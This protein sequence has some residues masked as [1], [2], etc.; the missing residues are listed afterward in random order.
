MNIGVIRTNTSDFG[1][2]G[3]YNVQE[4]GLA[5]ALI[6]MGHTVTVLYL[7][8]DT[9]KII[10]DETYSFVFYLPHR[11]IGLHGI[12]DV[13]LL[14]KY[15]PNGVILFSDNQLWAK[16]VIEWCCKKQIKCIQYM[17]NVLSD[18]PKW[19]HQFYTKLILMRNI[20]SYNKSIN[21]SKTNKVKE[22]MIRLH[23]P[24]TKIINIGLDDSILQNTYSIDWEMRRKLGFEEDETVLLFIGRI[25][26]YKKPF[27]ACDIL[28]RLN[29]NGRKTKMIMIGKGVLQNQL[30]SYIESQGLK[31]MI[32]Y[33]ERVPYEKIYQYMVSS[34]CFINLSA[35]EIFG[36]TV[37][38]AMY[39]KLPVVVHSAPGPNDIVEDG[40]TGY[41]CESD[42]VEQWCMLI[43]KALLNRDILGES[44]HTS[45]AENFMWDSSAGQFM[46]LF[47]K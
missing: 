11:T 34:N 5:N 8:K 28:K 22:E 10:Q 40:K 21:V 31:D 47:E 27:L 42:D 29:E 39:Y 3:T 12:F 37:L 16:N 41:I 9:K 36:M 38:E 13:R 44:A 30:L 15:N 23:V 6:K 18:N 4:V 46:E 2:I 1:K 35:I 24:F 17:G 26:D 33:I 19:L 25:V 14:E 45:I 43:E 20:R 7:N 32:M